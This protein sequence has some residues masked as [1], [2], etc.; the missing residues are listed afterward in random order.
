MILDD[1]VALL[2]DESSSL[3]AALLKTKVLLHN[4]GKKELVEWANNE[5]NGYPDEAQLP[6]YRVLPSVVLANLNSMT[7]QAERHPIPIA[8]LGADREASLEHTPMYQSLAV[9]QEMSL[10]KE[11]LMRAIPMEWIGILELGLAR[12]VRI[13]QAWCHISADDITGIFLQVRSRLLDFLLELKDTVGESATASELRQKSNSLDARRMFN[14]AIFG[15]GA[16][17]VVGDH[18]IQ[19]VRSQ[20]TPG[21]LETLTQALAKLGI[22]A[23]EIQNLETAVTDDQAHGG[24]P[25]F[26]GKT[27]AWFT[28]L[29][30]RAARGTLNASVDV[31]SAG[32]GKALSAFL[33]LPP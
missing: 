11:G 12:G 28:N 2:S 21:N 14:N 18:N 26:E 5:L 22:P 10:R 6:E 30:A 7:F 19:S 17:I 8:H 1:I 24:K 13:Q 27:G 25:S 31:V 20:I 33:G 16:T 15:A 32:V 3:T 4:I 9:L 23:D 29:L